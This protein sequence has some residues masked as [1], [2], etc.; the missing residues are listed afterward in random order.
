MLLWQESGDGTIT[1]RLPSLSGAR[2]SVQSGEERLSV[3]LGRAVAAGE[4]L[5]W[6]LAPCCS[7]ECSETKFL[8]LNPC[9]GMA[10]LAFT[11][12]RCVWHASAVIT[13]L[14]RVFGTMSSRISV[15]TCSRKR[16]TSLGWE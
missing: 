4:E 15:L 13:T 11:P 3:S 12:L 16:C 10:F 1:P 14:P 6:K 5:R 2:A 7:H 8:G 9:L